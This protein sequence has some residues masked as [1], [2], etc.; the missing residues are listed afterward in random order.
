[1]LVCLSFWC[2]A[3]RFLAIKLLAWN[4]TQPLYDVIYWHVYTEFYIQ[5]WAILINSMMRGA[6]S[7]SYYVLINDFIV[8][9]TR[10]SKEDVATGITI[11]GKKHQNMYGCR[12]L[13][14]AN[15]LLMF[16]RDPQAVKDRTHVLFLGSCWVHE[17]PAA[18]SD[19]YLVCL[20]MYC[21]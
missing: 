10:T 15:I 18:E 16:L 12:S 13:F 2:S 21:M 5:I 11:T 20:C 9:Q 14:V 19:Q 7:S 8:N 1:M 4:A 3:A 17:K 6:N